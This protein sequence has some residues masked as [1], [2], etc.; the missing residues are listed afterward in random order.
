MRFHLS[1]SIGVPLHDH[2]PIILEILNKGLHQPKSSPNSKVEEKALSKSQASPHP[3]EK[4]TA[5]SSPPSEEKSV[6][7]TSSPSEEKAEKPLTKSPQE[8]RHSVSDTHSQNLKPVSNAKHHRK[9]HGHGHSDFD[10]SIESDLE[11]STSS[12]SSVTS[13]GSGKGKGF[14]LHF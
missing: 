12:V 5:K 7:K 1:E 3:E 14:V 4:A 6:N 9:S 13:V 8:D 11:A 10:S 2:Q